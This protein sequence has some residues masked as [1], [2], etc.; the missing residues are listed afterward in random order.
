[1]LNPSEEFEELIVSPLSSVI[2]PAA[3]NVKLCAVAPMREMLVV[4]SISP[5]WVPLM[6]VVIDTSVPVTSSE[7]TIVDA[8]RF[9]LFELGV[10][11]PVVVL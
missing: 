2:F 9:E 5:C 4:M 8:L 11:V 1:M 7:V 6:P 10:Y 3:F